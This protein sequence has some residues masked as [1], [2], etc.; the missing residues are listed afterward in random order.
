MAEDL[1][2]KSTLIALTPKREPYWNRIAGVEGLYVGY[3]KLEQGGGTWIARLRNDEKRQQYRAL[4]S[5]HTYQTAVRSAQ[6]WAADLSKGVEKFDST[7]ADA[8]RLY[9][10]QQKLN[11]S[12]ATAKDA[13]GRFERLVY[14]AAIGKVDLAKL[15]TTTLRSWLNAQV[16]ADEDDDP[17]W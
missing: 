6:E 3:R 4:G 9:V 2:K 14:N 7:V 8:C 17:W 10:E 12:K 5:G 16:P 15:K 13:K 11:K 1:S